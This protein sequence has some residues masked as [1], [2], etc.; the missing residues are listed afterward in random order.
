MEKVWSFLDVA[1]AAI[2]KFHPSQNV[3]SQ[4]LKNSLRPTPELLLYLYYIK[5]TV[6]LMCILA[7]FWEMCL[8]FESGKEN[9]GLEKV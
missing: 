6:H 3:Q 5:V 9:N 4:E 2:V 7:T 8:F 1:I